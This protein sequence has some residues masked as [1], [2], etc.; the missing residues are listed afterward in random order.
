MPLVWKK[1]LQNKVWILG[2]IFVAAIGGA[3]YIYKGKT[4]P[5]QVGP[6]VQV[7]RGDISSMV[8]ATGTISPVNLVDVSSKITGL[9][10]EVKVKENDIVSVGQVLLMLDDTHLQALVS[11]AQARLS[12]ATGIYERTQ[13][14]EALGAVTTQALD[15]SRSDY[16]VAQAAY[17]DAVSQL[18]DTVIRSPINGQ[19]IGKPTPAGQAV[20]PGVSTPM[21]LLTIADMS[22]MQ[23][24]TQVDESDIGKIQ[25]GQKV[26]FTVDAYPTKTFSGVVSNVSQKATV[27]SNVVYYKVLVDVDAAEN[28]LKPTMTARVSI[29]VAESKNTLVVP[30]AAVKSNNNGQYVVV[31][32]QNVSQ[33]VSVTTGIT[34]DSKIE[35]VSGLSEGD[36]IV[37]SSAKTQ[38]TNST[39]G[40]MRSVGGPGGM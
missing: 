31:V 39:K 30:I 19:V 1:V 29:H 8:S 35:I 5:V 11:Q 18:N 32:K 28:L 4:T 21:V 7:E 14:L 17:E 9:I 37:A 25:V 27:V 23:I 13:R 38:T 2:L 10:K 33:N 16:S 36:E 34:G 12:N 20:A 24:E 15:T 40:G 26:T 22:K 3:I 6:T